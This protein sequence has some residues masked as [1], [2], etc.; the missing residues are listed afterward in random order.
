M[1]ERILFDRTTTGA[2]D[3]FQVPDGRPDRTFQAIVAGTGSVSATVVV[4]VSSNNVDWMTLGTITLSGTTRAAD[5]FAS[6]AP[7]PMVRGNVTAL[8][9]TDARVALRMGT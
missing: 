9:G 7:W 5:G 8:S 6:R 2:G 1:T 3:A 4:E